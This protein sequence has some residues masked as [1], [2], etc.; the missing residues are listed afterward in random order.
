MFEAYSF[1]TEP[2]SSFINLE[3]L[4]V[5]WNLFLHSFK[6]DRP[7]ITYCIIDGLHELDKSDA[8]ALL[9]LLNGRF[10][11]EGCLETGSPLKVLVISHDQPL[12]GKYGHINID[13]QQDGQIS[14]NEVGETTI[15]SD[16]PS[17]VS[18]TDDLRACIPVLETLVAYRQPPTLEQFQWF[19]DEPLTDVKQL[20]NSCRSFIEV[21]GARR[22]SFLE[23][24]YHHLFSNPAGSLAVHSK[25]AKRCLDVLR[26]DFARIDMEVLEE[27]NSLEKKIGVNLAYAIEHWAEH[28]KLSQDTSVAMLDKLIATFSCNAQTLGKF[29]LVYTRSLFESSSNKL[30]W[31]P[32]TSILHL[33]AHFGFDGLLRTATRSTRWDRFKRYLDTPDCLDKEPLSYAILGGHTETVKFFLHGDAE[34]NS[35]HVE[36]AA[37]TSLEVADLLFMECVRDSLTRL[38]AHDIMNRAVIG[39]DVKI[40][41]RTIEVLSWVCSDG[42]PCTLARPLKHAIETGRWELVEPL[43]AI[44]KL[45]TNVEDILHYA[46]MR[47]E[48]IFFGNLLDDPR[49]RE[50]MATHKSDMVNTLSIAL[51]HKCPTMVSL[52]MTT[53]NLH[54]KD[55]NGYNPLQVAAR[56]ANAQT[57]LCFLHHDFSFNNKTIEEGVAL[58]L[59]LHAAGTHIDPK[60]LSLILQRGARIRYEH[61]GIT[62]LHVA[63]EIGRTRTMKILLQHLSMAEV[64]ADI[65]RQCTSKHAEQGR[66]DFTPLAIAV[67]RG[68]AGIV[69]LLVDAGARVDGKVG[70]RTLVEVAEE[71]GWEEIV[72]V[73]RGEKKSK[74]DGKGKKGRKR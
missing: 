49:V 70:G 65:E 26:N 36:Y 48:G 4:T 20:V 38:E 18:D 7:G 43:L 27:N 42:F 14:A 59:M 8:T 29:W 62:A 22:I 16:T 37:G 64:K 61:F 15:T 28:V 56:H 1:L 39:G 41:K 25:L 60:Y 31:L 19:F 45:D 71:A 11:F 5:M 51:E 66:V 21:D 47:H 17:D 30:D 10:T 44:T 52:V 33:F 50:A 24:S 12:S 58:N 46:A 69:I 23:S 68:F 3:K 13:V 40:L 63:A 72:G 6:T 54:K 34:Y 73:L 35:R 53:A 55:K 67:T 57:M 32:H 2:D 74:A 9:M